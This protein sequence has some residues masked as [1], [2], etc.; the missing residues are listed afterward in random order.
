VVTT[1]LTETQLI[2]LL[3]TPEA[4]R[5]LALRLGPD[6]RAT[7]LSDRRSTFQV[8][9]AAQSYIVRLPQDRAHLAALCREARIAAA[10]QGRTALRVPNTRVVEGSPT[11]ALHDMIPGEPLTTEHYAQSSPAAQERLVGDLA[12]FFRQMH[13]IRLS[14][15]CE[16]LDIPIETGD[17]ATELA[18]RYGKPLWFAP[19]EVAAMRPELVPLLDAGTWPTFERTVAQFEALGPHPEHMVFGHGDLHGY[20]AAVLQDEL[21]PRL[22]GV[23][24]LENTGILDIHEDFFRLSLVSEALL[25]DVLAAYGRLPRPARSLDRARIAVYYRAFLFY[26]MAGKTGERLAH[27]HRLLA[28]HLAYCRAHGIGGPDE[29]L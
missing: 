18:P 21:G 3:K 26:L 12:R 2:G 10:L 13:S 11:F 20:N 28:Q 1:R 9:D 6:A 22:V 5:Q 4:D 24:D 19:D 23:F 15:A 27:L 17:P 16:W 25:D 14:Q 7:S 8:S 29:L